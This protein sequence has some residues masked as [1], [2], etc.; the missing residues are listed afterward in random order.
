MPIAITRQVS[1]GIS[2]CELTHLSREPINFQLA[3]DQHR[4]YEECL[5]SLGCEM[6]SLPAEPELPDSVFVED[7]AIVLDEVAVVTRSGAASR[8][9]EIPAIVEALR[10]YRELVRIEAPATLDGGD[11]LRMGQTLYVGLSRRSNRIALDQLRELLKPF[12]NRI[13]GVDVGRCLHLKSA[14]TRVA[15]NTLLI[16]S[17]WVNAAAFSGATFI[18]VDP[19]E[20]AAANALMINNS[21]VF[22]A[23]YPLTRERLESGGISIR[24]VDV[25][26]LTK[27]EGSV[28]CCSLIFSK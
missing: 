6:R 22:P 15:E 23:Q 13:E 10:P 21:V 14:I 5:A 19:L 3:Q 17:G 11:V 2:D 18:D 1:P 28:T 26:E 8:R 7:A 12:G 27:A 24:E 25:S 16:N 9:A 20:P 4:K